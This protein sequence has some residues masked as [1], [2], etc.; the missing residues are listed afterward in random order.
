MSRRWPSFASGTSACLLA[1]SRF[2]LLLFAAC[3]EGSTRAKPPILSVS[4]G[5]P[6]H[7]IYPTLDLNGHLSHFVAGDDCCA[8]RAFLSCR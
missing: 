4:Q 6:T 1:T 7:T 2:R 3:T 8:P 5:M